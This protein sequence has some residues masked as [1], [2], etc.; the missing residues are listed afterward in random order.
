MTLSVVY[1]FVLLA[2]GN[3]FYLPI[4]VLKGNTAPA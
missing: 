2:L 3:V 4:L 1:D